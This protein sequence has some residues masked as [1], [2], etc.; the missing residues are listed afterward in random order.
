[1]AHVDWRWAVERTLTLTKA[2][3]KARK[4]TSCYNAE[5]E[6]RVMVGP[7][8]DREQAV[9]WAIANDL[10][11]KRAFKIHPIIPDEML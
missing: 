9:S 2:E 1:M 8:H 6:Y 10:G 11:S 4:L 3:A 5:G 7:F